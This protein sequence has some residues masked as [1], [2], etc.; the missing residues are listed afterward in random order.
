MNPGGGVSNLLSAGSTTSS[1][2]K[3]D[4]FPEEEET[5]A[6]GVKLAGKIYH[7]SDFCDTEV[8]Q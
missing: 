2:G 8:K 7:C 3:K 6:D 4:F 1:P 5:V